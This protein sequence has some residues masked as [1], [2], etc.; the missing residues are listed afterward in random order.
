MSGNYDAR[1]LHFSYEENVSET[2]Y[3]LATRVS[4][5][6]SK[7]SELEHKAALW[8]AY[9]KEQEAVRKANEERELAREK[10]NKKLAQHERMLARVEAERERIL[11]L[12]AKDHAKLAELDGAT[13]LP[14]EVA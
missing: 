2:Q 14:T 8:D 5:L 13:V 12:I 11:N 1:P 4:E 6:E 9:Q 3:K 7:Q 10:T